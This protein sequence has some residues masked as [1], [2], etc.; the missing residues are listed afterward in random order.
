MASQNRPA[1]SETQDSAPQSAFDEHGLLT[2]LGKGIT[3][4]PHA[5]H[6]IAIASARMWAA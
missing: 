3:A 1:G 2:S 5:V 4:P 6:A